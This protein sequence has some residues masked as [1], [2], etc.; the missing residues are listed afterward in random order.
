MWTFIIVDVVIVEALFLCAG[1]TPNGVLTVAK[2]LGTHAAVLTLFQLLPVPDCRGWT[3]A[4]ADR[5]T[6]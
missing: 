3:A 1:S 6:V 4:S 2:F 5:L